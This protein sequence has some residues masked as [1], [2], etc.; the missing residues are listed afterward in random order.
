M[1]CLS[2]QRPSSNLK[3]GTASL[4]IGF[5]PP[6]KH[7]LRGKDIAATSGASHE[8][9]DD[10]D[11]HNDNHNDHKRTNYEKLKR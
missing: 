7:L 5:P 1:Q 9:D 3:L 2:T 8:L 11:D 6:I 10:H 4:G